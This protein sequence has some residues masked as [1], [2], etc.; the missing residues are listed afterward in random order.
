MKQVRLPNGWTEADV[1]ELIEYYDHQ[2]D[3]EAALEWEARDLGIEDAVVVVP[4]ELVPRVRALRAE[5]E[6][7]RRRVQRRKRRVPLR[8]RGK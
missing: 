6:R 5:F 1:R 4:Y 2:T 8:K 7:E 3:D